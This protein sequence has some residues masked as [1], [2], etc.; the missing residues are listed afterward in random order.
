MGK[1]VDVEA[2]M[3]AACDNAEDLPLNSGGSFTGSIAEYL[4]IIREALKQFGLDMAAQ[5]LPALAKFLEEWQPKRFLM[6]LL[7][8]QLLA[9]IY[10]L[11]TALETDPALGELAF[12]QVK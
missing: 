8:K 9:A 7:R 2:K 11:Q 6:K 3:M 10:E 1:H 4:P 5:S 12:Y